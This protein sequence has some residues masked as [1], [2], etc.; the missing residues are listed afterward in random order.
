LFAISPYP[1]RYLRYLALL[2]A[3]SSDSTFSSK[4]TF[5]M[6]VAQAAAGAAARHMVG[7]EV[8][9]SRPVLQ[10]PNYPQP[11]HTVSRFNSPC[12]Q[13]R[14]RS[15]HTGSSAASGPPRYQFKLRML[16][17]DGGRLKLG[18]LASNRCTGL[19]AKYTV[20][21]LSL[22]TQ[23]AAKAVFNHQQEYTS[24]PLSC[25]LHAR[26]C[27][28]SLRCLLDARHSHPLSCLFHAPC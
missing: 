7:R 13:T 28:I 17:P 6:R 4:S 10:V 22:D 21:P 5:C 18:S 11:W 9:P 14:A 27:P 12:S 24:Q 15:A 1:C 8:H 20:G 25:L 2:I 26:S 16:N 19:V 23:W 3:E